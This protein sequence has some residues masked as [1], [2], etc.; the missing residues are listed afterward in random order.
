[1]PKISTSETTY[2]VENQDGSLAINGQL[3]DWDLQE[4]E[5]GKFHAVVGSRSVNLEV[6]SADYREKS[7]VI[8]VNGETYHYTVKDQFDQLLEK[9]GLNQMTSQKVAELKAP[10]PGLV[11]EFKVKP[12]DE[13]KKGD[14]LVVLE[15]MKMENIL[16][17]PADVTVKAISV[18][19]G[20]TVEKNEVIIQFA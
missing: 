14:P 20:Q 17:S 6:V 5:P 2:E 1:M 12:G 9:M 10:M 8:K 15:A 7:F 18:E 19:Q 3:L 13:V 4:V 16:K 11:L